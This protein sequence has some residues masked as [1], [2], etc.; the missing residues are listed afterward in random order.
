MIPR[1]AGG[2]TAWDDIAGLE[3]AKNLIKEIVVWPM[4]N[5][6]L[7]TVCSID[8][9]WHQLLYAVMCASSRTGQCHCPYYM[10]WHNASHVP[11][12]SVLWLM[13]LAS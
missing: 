13:S 2:G 8:L 3:T 9:G 6:E 5:P 1:G 4:M 12:H 10:H 7:F 11:A